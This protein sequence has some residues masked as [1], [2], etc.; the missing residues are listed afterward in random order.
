MQR[1]L[2]LFFAMGLANLS[3]AWG[4]EPL[5]F[6]RDV[7][8]ILSAACYRCHG[9]DAKARQAELRLDVPED[10]LKARDSGAAVVPGKP[11]ESQLWKRII[12]KDPDMVMPPPDSV[13][14]LTDG[15]R[16]ILRRWLEQGGK[17]QKHWRSSQSR[18]QLSQ[19]LWKSFKVRP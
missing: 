15:E 7:R 14:Q 9:F 12:S 2:A 4:E 10:A 1:M 19:L 13:R 18:L 11:D 16:D 5:E 6:N 3:V 8:P 17:Y